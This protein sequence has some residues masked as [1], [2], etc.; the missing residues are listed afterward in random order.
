MPNVNFQNW[1]AGIIAS[2]TPDES[3]VAYYFGIFE[4]ETHYTIYLTG[5]S[6]YDA[7]DS[8]WACSNDFEPK[9]K[10]FVLPSDFNHLTW[11]EVLKKVENSLKDFVSS[12]LYKN[13]FFSRAKVIATGFDDGD[14]IEIHS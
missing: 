11:D 8:D 4:G 10:Y 5:S 1:L 3:I 2:E 7:S 12:T 6:V 14:L 9:E 13:S